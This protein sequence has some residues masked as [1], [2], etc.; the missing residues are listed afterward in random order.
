MMKQLLLFLFCL[1]PAGLRANADT[2]K[3]LKVL[4]LNVWQDA[5]QVDG[6]FEAIADEVAAHRPDIVTLCEVRDYH[7]VHFT[8]SL[9]R[10]LRGKGLLYYTCPSKDGGIL[11]RYPIVESGA[12]DSVSINRAVIDVEGRQMAVYAV[13]YDRHMKHLAC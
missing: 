5:T 2:G 3:Q 10:S 8:D 7:G 13:F 4:Q 11:S 1:L 12:L 9:C 6:A